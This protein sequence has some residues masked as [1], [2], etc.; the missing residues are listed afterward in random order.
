MC[1]FN[2]PTKETDMK[3]PKITELRTATKMMLAA[4]VAR[5]SLSQSCSPTKLK[6]WPTTFLKSMSAGRHTKLDASP[7]PQDAW[8]MTEANFLAYLGSVN[9]LNIAAGYPVS[10][11]TVHC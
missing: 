6:Y 8:L 4:K 3:P 10:S 7:N 1:S 9:Q 5:Q 11:E 2:Q